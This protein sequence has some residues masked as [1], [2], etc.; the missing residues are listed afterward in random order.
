[1]LL[2]NINNCIAFSTFI[3]LLCML[4]F[5]FVRKISR[6]YVVYIIHECLLKS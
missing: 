4:L 3:K 1:M 6:I 5:N 2:L